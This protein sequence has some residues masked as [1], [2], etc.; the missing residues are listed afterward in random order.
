MLWDVGVDGVVAAAKNAGILKKLRSLID[1]LTLPAKHKKIK[2]RGIVPS[3]RE[4]ATPT[5]EEDE[6]EE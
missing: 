6:E 3:L 2:A 1:G 4:A 5:I